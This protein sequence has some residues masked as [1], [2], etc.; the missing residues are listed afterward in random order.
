MKKEN[1]GVGAPTETKRIDT[2]VDCSTLKCFVCDQH[3]V[4]DD[5]VIAIFRSVDEVV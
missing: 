5:I 3:S 1:M 2:N 4:I